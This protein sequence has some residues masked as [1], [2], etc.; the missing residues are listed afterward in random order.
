MLKG[1]VIAVC[2]WAALGAG[3]AT[4]AADP[5]ARSASRPARAAAPGVIKLVTRNVNWYRTSIGGLVVFGEIVN[6]GSN[7]VADVGVLVGL[8]NDRGERL[9]RGA[10][11]KISV[12]VLRPRATAV[13]QAQMTDNPRRW[14]RM[15]IETGEQIGRDAARK[16]DYTRFRVQGVRIA[17]ANP[18]FSQKVTG[19]VVNVGGKPA[20]VGAVT[21]ALYA[22]GG[23]LVHVTGQ[24]FLYPYSTKQVVP[25]RRSAPFTATILGYTKKPARIV[26][27][28]RASTKDANGFYLP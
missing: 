22:R 3:G 19:R 23:R 11:L 8:Y 18:G 6:R 12:N 20:K 9:A 28:V 13:W 5:N 1:A 17:E 26:T 27:Y 21:V 25:P 10:T 16:Q 15:K 24:G 7:D 2:A 14:S 4:S